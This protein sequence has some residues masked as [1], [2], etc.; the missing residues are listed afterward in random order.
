MVKAPEKRRARST[1]TQNTRDALTTMKGLARASEASGGNSLVEQDAYRNAVKGYVSETPPQFLPI[2]YNAAQQKALEAL[3]KLDTNAADYTKKHHHIIRGL[4]PK[5]RQSILNLFEV[6]RFSPHVGRT[7][8]DP[9]TGMISVFAPG[10]KEPM[11][12]HP[13]KD[14]LTAR[15]A[16][17]TAKTETPHGTEPGQDAM[18]APTPTTSP[19]STLSW[20]KR[21]AGALAMLPE[22]EEGPP[23]TKAGAALKTA[24]EQ[25]GA[26]VQ[27]AL[28][29][30]C[31]TLPRL[32]KVLA[33]YNGLPLWAKVV[34]GGILGAASATAVTTVMATPV[35]LSLLSFAVARGASGALGGA[36]FA[37]SASKIFDA[38]YAKEYPVFVASAQ[39][40]AGV[41]GGLLF[42]MIFGNIAASEYLHSLLNPTHAPHPALPPLSP[43]IVQPI[44]P[45]PPPAMPAPEL[46]PI[47]PEP[48][49]L[50]P[51]PEP[52]IPFH[53]IPSA[54]GMTPPIIAGDE[55][56]ARLLQHAID[57]SIH[58]PWAAPLNEALGTL[59]H[60]LQASFIEVFWKTLDVHPHL[61]EVLFAT[62]GAE[63]WAWNAIPDG[64]AAHFDAVFSQPDFAE[65]FA[66]VAQSSSPSYASL[67]REFGGVEGLKSALIQLTQH[68]H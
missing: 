36:L 14:A 20:E 41:A 23:T 3:Q 13:I 58:E 18:A 2:E 15:A 1:I 40:F 30:S 31:A 46:V 54:E 8:L 47:N 33:L 56:V 55:S 25:S 65:R 4:K 39:T 59:P 45:E 29:K 34:T 37:K 57:G 64:T 67:V 32:R 22:D 24:L 53:H 42:A 10:K 52:A 63:H 12:V 27:N 51:H 9:T 21:L 48:P 19:E 38:E 11:S 61:K 62:H 16:E 28:D 43:E 49:L 50:V 7:Q 26:V 5:D 44:T 35:T 68:Y 6:P 17:I 60:N 66:H